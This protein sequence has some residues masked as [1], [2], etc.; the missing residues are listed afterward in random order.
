MVFYGSDGIIVCTEYSSVAGLGVISRQDLQV[1]LTQTIVF[2]FH[3]LRFV[4]FGEWR[5]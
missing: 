4:A 1:L 3:S 5:G 2:C